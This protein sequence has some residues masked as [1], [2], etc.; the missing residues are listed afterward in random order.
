MEE[1]HKEATKFLPNSPTEND[2]KRAFINLQYYLKL[3]KSL[4]RVKDRLSSYAITKR[5]YPIIDVIYHRLLS[6]YH[7]DDSGNL[8]NTNGAIQPTDITPD[9]HTFSKKAQSYRNSYIKEMLRSGDRVLA[10]KFGV[11]DLLFQD[12]QA[13]EERKSNTNAA[14]TEQITELFALYEETMTAL[15]SRNPK[16]QNW[17]V[18]KL[19]QKTLKT[20][21]KDTKVDKH[22]YLIESVDRVR[23]EIDSIKN[24]LKV[25]LRTT[26]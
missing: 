21:N 23:K 25:H 4:K 2:W 16:K 8:T 12:Y 1:I 13:A 17:G 5:K 24:S 14:L 18:Y 9:A 11:K 19:H 6:Y 3:D 26:Q 20:F 7:K 10:I 15:K 22:N